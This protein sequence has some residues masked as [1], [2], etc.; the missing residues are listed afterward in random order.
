V[1]KEVACVHVLMHLS[2]QVVV[3]PPHDQ[4][5]TTPLQFELHPIRS[6]VPSSHVSDE[7]VSLFPFPQMKKQVELHKSLLSKFPSSH[8][9]GGVKILFPQTGLHSSGLS[10]IG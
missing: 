1:K 7:A 4:V 10:V 3:P 2:G 9:S 6:G 5:A 8:C